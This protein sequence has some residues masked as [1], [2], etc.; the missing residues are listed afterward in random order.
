MPTPL[1][2]ASNNA[3]KVTELREMLAGEDYDVLSPAD[4]GLALEVDETG[5]TFSENARLKAEAFR[6]RT[7]LLS[8]ADDS[9]LV[10]DVLDGQP[11]VYSARYGG[12]S[13]TDEVRNRMILKRLEAVPDS[14]RTARFVAAIAIAEPVAETVIFVGTVEGRIAQAPAGEHGFGYDPIFYYPPFGATL[15][16]V[17]SVRK[18]TVSHRGKALREAL[19]YLRGRQPHDILDGH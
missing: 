1:L 3:H 16:Q 18:A 12:P 7:G 6:E 13:A 2:I 19:S 4:A 11:G 8:L 9:G 17:S 5:A 14:Q 15:A 10:V